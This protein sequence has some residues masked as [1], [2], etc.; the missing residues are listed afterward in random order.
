MAHRP[1]VPADLDHPRRLWAR[2][3]TLGL[4][5]SAGVEEN[6]YQLRERVL[7][8]DSSGGSYWWRLTRHPDGR[9]V[10]CG[11]DADG[12][13]GHLR[14]DPV[15]FLVGGPDWLPWQDLRYEQDGCELGYVYWWQDGGWGRAPYPDDL[16][17]DG[18]ELAA[19]WVSGDA[20]LAEQLWEEAGYGD[21]LNAAVVTFL[22][23][24]ERRTVDEEAVTA[25]LA[26]FSAG[27]SPGPQAVA[28]ALD[29]ASRAALTPL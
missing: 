1:S 8:C 3:S 6:D 2:A 28:T 26:A 15:D 29:F 10:F 27:G 12:S 21:G 13:H 9:T 19:G 11:R 22:D 5:A 16:V 23:R 25:L 17:D 14:R 7:R 18:L 4:L 20:R 24:A